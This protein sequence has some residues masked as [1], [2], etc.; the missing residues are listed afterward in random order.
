MSNILNT[1]NWEVG[2]FSETL[3]Q[4]EN[5]DVLLFNL[6]NPEYGGKAS[7][8][9]LPLPKSEISILSKNIN[10][11]EIIVENKQSALYVDVDKVM[12]SYIDAVYI[13]DSMV[14]HLY[15]LYGDQL[16]D[17]NITYEIHI[18]TASESLINVMK[19]KRFID[20]YHIVF[21]V[22]CDNNKCVKRIITDFLTYHETIKL[23]L[24]VYDRNKRFRCLNQSKP[25]SNKVLRKLALKH[26]KVV[27]EPRKNITPNDFITYITEDHIYIELVEPVVYTI[28]QNAKNYN[29]KYNINQ[30]T[31]AE[32]Y[33]KECTTSEYVNGS[34]W[35][36]ILCGILS[37]FIL[38]NQPISITHSL[39]VSFLDKSKVGR[40][41]EDATIQE[42]NIKYI[43][44]IINKTR[45]E[46][47]QIITQKHETK[48]KLKR[49]LKHPE[50]EF[51]YKKLN[52][53]PETELTITNTSVKSKD[54]YNLQFNTLSSVNY[55]DPKK[56]FLLENV[57]IEDEKL[58]VG[59][60]SS[61]TLDQISNTQYINASTIKITNLTE[62]DKNP[63]ISTYTVAPTGTGKSHICMKADI[64]NIL[65]ES[66]TNILG[67]LTETI[68]LAYKHHADLL[69]YG[70]DSETIY[71]YKD[72]TSVITERTRIA[73]IC[74]NSLLTI[75]G[76]IDFT[77]VII[78]EYV[79]L[80]NS[81]NTDLLSKSTQSD[82][83]NYL[84]KILQESE[85]IK[86][87]DASIHDYDIKFLDDITGK[88]F[89]YYELVG[90]IQ[91]NNTAILCS[92]DIQIQ[93]MYDNLDKKQ[94]FVIASG[95]KGRVKEIE[96]ALCKHPSK[97][98]ILTISS[99]GATDNYL[100]VQTA[101]E[102]RSLKERVIKD[103]TLW[104]VYDIVIYTPTVICG[105]SFNIEDVFYTIYVFMSLFG[106]N[107]QQQS[108]MIFRVRHTIS[109]TIHLC[110]YK[111]SVNSLQNETVNS[112][113]MVDDENLNHLFVNMFSNTE[114]KSYIN[115]TDHKLKNDLLYYASNPLKYWEAI[116]TF[117]AS[118]DTQIKLFKLFQNLKHWGVQNYKLEFYET[119]SIPV[120][121]ILPVIEPELDENNLQILTS[122]IFK[123]YVDFKSEVMVST[124][125]SKSTEYTRAEIKTMINK[126]VG[127]NYQLY[128]AI[129]DANPSYDAF[130]FFKVNLQ[131]LD[132]LK[133]Y[134][135]QRNIQY[136]EVKELIYYIF[137]QPLIKDNRLPKANIPDISTK[138]DEYFKNKDFVNYT[139]NILQLYVSFKVF[140]LAGVQYS[141][142]FT[143]FYFDG[144][145]ELNIPP[146]NE[147]ILSKRDSSAPDV[148]PVVYTNIISFIKD[149]I[150]T[151]DK[152]LLEFYFPKYSKTPS[153]FLSKMILGLNI[154]CSVNDTTKFISLC[155]PKHHIKCRFQKTRY[156]NIDNVDFDD[157][158]NYFPDKSLYYLNTIFGILPVGY[159][160][161]LPKIK[162][163]NLYDESNNVKYLSKMFEY[164]KLFL[165]PDVKLNFDK[166][167][168]K[169]H[170]SSITVDNIIKNVLYY[171]NIH[172][173]IPIPID[174]LTN[175]PIEF[176]PFS[177]LILVSKNGDILFNNNILKQYQ[178][179]DVV[180][181]YIYDDEYSV[182][183][184]VYET[185]KSPIPPNN[186]VYHINGNYADNNINNLDISIQDIDK[187]NVA[188]QLISKN[189][190]LAK[191]R[192]N[193][194]LTCPDC[195]VSF[196]RRHKSEH[197]C[198]T[199]PIL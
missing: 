24:K 112:T 75:E 69:S 64:L 8:A 177:E 7:T 25:E 115:T 105:I 85:S 188:D 172:P 194:R 93:K 118:E 192:R 10:A 74:Y 137:E 122:T 11:F 125:Q 55:Y 111:D 190:E 39:I 13:A 62:T 80:T 15:T 168:R 104:K 87:Y 187:R 44:S 163:V 183:N 2:H 88:T 100:T 199:I 35:V 91:N 18:S 33:L 54:Y 109:K 72:K 19:S 58:T 65:K 20:S 138:F 127:F 141:Q 41:A 133:L 47:I 165:I 49:L 30:T 37:V 130:I 12:H 134:N 45:V 160:K 67:I 123:E 66:P 179:D 191:N 6:M 114:V 48:S 3:I 152:T 178:K 38:L 9:I 71:F 98:R 21:N 77:H 34:T 5:D 76:K 174:P 46:L 145:E 32:T 155:A 26:N 27:L 148:I 151:Y 116:N 193:E 146:S 131:K 156:K 121:P 53:P 107:Y 40:F 120:Q 57:I 79:N 42:K 184:L 89:T 78:D 36:R 153:K 56:M 142:F 70:I 90:N 117:I 181:V 140:E 161:D 92:Y 102:Q 150:K 1:V 51:V 173:N 63:S 50:I 196:T 86:I 154:T 101:E 52:I 147:I 135:Q 162:S 159:V 17:K 119:H 4:L 195:G 185:Y 132:R 171:E 94:K 182:K 103:T 136:Y 170:N 166:L 189:R 149:F 73:I 81:F 99:T 157:V 95:E 158:I 110:C 60:Q 84:I 43:N 113:T 108:Q 106:A 128:N 59:N 22:F 68:S 139:K 164:Y 124:I 169:T 198:D 176:K 23:D 143:L 29:F 167:V 180:N 126:K 61:Y 175:L 197:T 144:F 28:P 16:I 82:I 97:P 186:F 31:R 83:L 96:Q 129:S 14:N